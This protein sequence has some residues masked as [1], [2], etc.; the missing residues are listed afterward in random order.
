MKATLLD[1]SY[2]PVDSS[3][4]AFIMAAKLAYK[5]AIPEAGPV[6]LEPIGA[7]KATSPPTIPAILWARSRSA[8]AACWA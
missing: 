5:A 1:G 7:L 3:E 2:H 8:A 6:L 4:M